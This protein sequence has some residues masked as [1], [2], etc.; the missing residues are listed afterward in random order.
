[1]CAIF[2]QGDSKTTKDQDIV[3]LCDTG[4]CFEE[5][6]MRDAQEDKPT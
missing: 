6:S 1:M 4:M 2:I 5:C 3:N